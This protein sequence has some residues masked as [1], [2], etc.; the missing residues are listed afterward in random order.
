MTR[1]LDIDGP[2]APPRS[3]G[4]LIFGHPWQGRLFATTMAAGDADLIDHSEF[5][6]RLIAEVTERDRR[7]A[8]PKEYGRPSSTHRN[9]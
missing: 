2:G 9:R 5:R 4:E 7:E 6:G 1:E 8:G 3:N